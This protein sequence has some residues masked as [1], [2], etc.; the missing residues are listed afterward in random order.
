[1][2]GSDNGGP[3][4]KLRLE[5]CGGPGEL[6]DAVSG[7]RRVGQLFRPQPIPGGTRML[8]RSPRP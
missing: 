5:R 8:P 1:M 7:H 3:S 6:A 2:V 4:E